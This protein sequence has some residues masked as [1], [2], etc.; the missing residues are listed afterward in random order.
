MTLNVMELQG[1]VQ[2]FGEVTLQKTGDKVQSRPHRA[3][4]VLRHHP[5]GPM[6]FINTINKG[7]EQSCKKDWILFALVSS[8]PTAAVCRYHDRHKYDI[9]M[10]LAEE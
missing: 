10:T 9:A 5:P 4:T 3:F 1:S 2:S 8:Q 7:E 6:A